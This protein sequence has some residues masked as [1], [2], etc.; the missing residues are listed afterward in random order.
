MPHQDPGE[1]MG[2]VEFDRRR[3]LDALLAVGFVSMA[4]AIAYPVSRFLI[5]PAS[6][7]PASAS[8]GKAAALTPNSARI[9]KFGSRP[10]IVVRTADGDVRAFSAV[11]THLEC[12]VQFKRDTAQ[13]WC[14]CPTGRTT[15]AATSSRARPIGMPT[16]D[17]VT[18]DRL[19]RI[20]SSIRDLHSR[21]KSWKFSPTIA[22]SIV[23]IAWLHV[24]VER[25]GAA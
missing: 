19:S 22:A 5:P 9:F 15:W 10:G 21:R 11:C 17:G 1:T 3:L 18:D 23:S 12:T 24:G 13:L 4:V 8:A 14:A 20:E 2:P 7:E 16:R 6:G 25:T